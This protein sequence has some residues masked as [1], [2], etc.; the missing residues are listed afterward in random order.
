MSLPLTPS[1]TVGPYLHIGL[2][3]VLRLRARRAWHARCDPGRGHACST[4][5]ASRCPMR[6]VEIWQAGPDG[7]YPGAGAA[8][9]GFGRS[10]TVDGGRFSFVTCKPGAVPWPAGGRQA[11]HLDVGV[12]ARGLLKRAVTRMYFPDEAEANAADP[13]LAGARPRTA[14]DA[15]SGRRA[16]RDL[17]A[18]TSGCRATPRRCSSRCD[19]R[20]DLRAVRAARGG[21]RRGVGR[22]HAG[23]RASAGE[24]RGDCRRD[25]ASPGRLDRRGV[26]G[27]ARR[28]R[29]DRARP[30]A[31]SAT[32][33]SLSCGR[34]GR[35]SAGRP[36]D[37]FT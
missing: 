16:G 36:P 15:G 9:G 1:Q 18:S 28:R 10:D 19:L 12:F 25:P 29:R 6:F 11:P 31:P 20:R 34:C 33:P 5:R 32:L 8:F 37:T 14:F 2:V 23:S 27:R 13:V 3:A 30:V 17:C 26:P 21:V 35:R 4:A 7:R 22:G 24:R